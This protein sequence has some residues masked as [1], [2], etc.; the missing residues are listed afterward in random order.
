[1]K[2]I[3]VLVTG[4]GSVMGQSTYRAMSQS[5]FSK[6]LRAFVTNSHNLGAGFYFNQKNYIPTIEKSLIVPLAADPHY[7][8]ALHQ[9]VL[10]NDIDIIFSGTQHE[11]MRIAQYGL[12][13]PIVAVAKPEVLRLSHD[14]LETA[15][16]FERHN[17]RAPSTTLLSE[18]S[19][20]S[21]LLPVVLKPR[22]SSSSRNI[23]VI[24]TLKDWSDLSEHPAL[25]DPT[26]VIVQ[27]YIEGD[28][29]TCGCYIDRYTHTISTIILKR[30]LTADGATGYAQVISD[31][32]IDEYLHEICHALQQEGLDFGHVNIQLRT[33]EGIP[34]CFEINGR[35][36]STEAPKAVLG[37]N[38]VDAYI[39]NIVLQ[40]PYPYF[41]VQPGRQFLRYYEEVYF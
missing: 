2:K 40:E 18:I 24:H 13:N 36:S 12:M 26:Q 23:F 21:S 9:I 10:E 38:S 4:A 39:H 33:Q 3:N 25:S 7:E 29:Y 28:E 17:I 31:T 27:A 30:T 34:F 37:F 5:R 16:F 22:C 32:V 1:M 41:N 15:H 19:D 20:I 11:I 8:K 35:L 14:K 6:D